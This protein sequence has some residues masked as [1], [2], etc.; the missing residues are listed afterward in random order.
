[1][2]VNFST[3]LITSALVGSIILAMRSEGGRL[4]PAI[5]LVV[6]AIA[7]LIT[8]KVIQL[9]VAKFRI[10]VVFPAILTVA[11]GICWSRSSSKSA[12]TAA[13]VVTIAG[14]ILLL[15]ALKVLGGG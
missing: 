5:A 15:S 12:I 9:S 2:T 11:G 8:Y 14:L 13:S 1:M 10:D 7:A 6:A 3:A 4:V